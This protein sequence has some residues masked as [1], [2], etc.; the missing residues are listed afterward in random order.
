MVS[1]HMDS[2]IAVDGGGT[3]CRLVL[4]RGPDQVPVETG[5]ANVSTD[6]D[7]AVA[8]I[9]DGLAALSDRAAIG[10]AALHALPAY[11]GLAGVTDETLAARVTAALPLARARVEDDRPAAVRGALG[12]GDG[13][14][15]HCGTG[16][17]FAV[18]SGGHIRLA[19]GWGPRLGD[20]ASA[21]WIGR[22]SLS[23]V[24]SAL[25]GLTEQ[26]DFTAAL[27]AE[28]GP[29]RNMVAFAGTA[30]PA[31]FGRVA[32]RATAAAAQDDPVARRILQQGGDHIAETLPGLGW[33]PGMRVCLTGGIAPA[34]GPYLPRDL[35]RCL[36]EPIATPLEGA[37]AL[38][39]EFGRGT[40]T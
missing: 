7:G 16:S 36:A 5:P 10:A 34:Y 9:A 14:V 27:L 15:A 29:A 1:E 20:E 12:E 21:Q 24:L 25:D 23:A 13:A 28:Y 22:L 19:G 4:A 26:S 35:G 18:Q 37:I 33:R 30:S 8:A 2:V 31:E 39:R 11:L 3:R 40:T 38:A 6:F 32:V 17:F